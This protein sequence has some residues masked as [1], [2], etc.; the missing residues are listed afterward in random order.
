MK[1]WKGLIRKTLPWKAKFNRI[2][3]AI[4]DWVLKEFGN[5]CIT[6]MGICYKKDGCYE[7]WA[8]TGI[9][10]DINTMENSLQNDWT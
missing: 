6:T 5:N 3:S 7:R 10:E 8:F 9:E 1:Y 2:I 4:K